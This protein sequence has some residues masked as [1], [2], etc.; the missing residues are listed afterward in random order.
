[1]CSYQYKYN[2]QSTQRQVELSNLL[3]IISLLCIVFFLV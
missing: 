2:G 3:N 1:M